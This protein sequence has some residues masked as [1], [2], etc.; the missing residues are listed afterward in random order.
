MAEGCAMRN[1]NLLFGVALCLVVLLA[2]TD[3][4]YSAPLLSSSDKQA[5]FIS[6]LER[7]EPTWHRKE[8]VSLLENAGYHVDV[9]LDEDASI[10]FLKTGLASY[11]VIVLRTDSFTYEGYSYYCAGDD[12]TAKSRADF[13]AE[14]SQHEVQV[15]ACVGFSGAFIRDNYPANSLRKGLV[16]VVDGYSADLSSSFLKAGSA[17]YVGYYDANTLAWGRT[18]C[19][20]LKWLSYMARGDSVKDATLNLYV[21]VNRGHGQ[22]ALWPS[23]FSYGDVTYR[24]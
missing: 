23:M 12:V 19:M 16:F 22:T 1:T 17:V 20:S 14:I 2:S 6:P 5:V 9:V 7:W 15:G 3:A 8:Y 24:L 18:D 13:A 21:Y 11:D 4:T 10:S